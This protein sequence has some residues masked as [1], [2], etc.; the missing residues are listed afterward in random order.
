MKHD[1]WGLLCLPLLL[2]TAVPI[3]LG[4]DQE[5]DDL[6]TVNQ[7]RSI[8]DLICGPK[9]VQEVLRLYEKED[10]D[11]IRLVREI[12]WPEVRKGATLANVAQALEKRGIHTFAMDIFPSVRIVWNYPVIVHLNPKPGQEIGHYIVWLPESQKDTVKIWN[13]NAKVEQENE[14][15]WAKERSGAVLLT[16]P[17]PIDEP[18]RALKWVGLPF[19]DQ[20][21]DIL[22]WA[23]FIIGLG[24][25]VEAFRLHRVLSV[26]TINVGRK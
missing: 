6:E 7:E 20:M 15:L 9:C 4:D 25:A 19:Y 13:M 18:G 8:G 10:E 14:R 22:A 11:I 17:E 12:Q 16:S 26:C 23:I 2:L 24:L 21:E 5:A 3:L 1:C